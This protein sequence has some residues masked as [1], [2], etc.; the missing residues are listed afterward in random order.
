MEY[1]I[2]QG[3]DIH[4][5]VEGRKLILGGVEIPFEKGLAGHS[6]ADA[7][8]HAV[9]DAALGAAGMGDI[10]E[11]FPPSDMKWKGADSRELL[12][13]AMDKVRAAGWEVVNLDATI[14]AE[15][16]KLSSWKP[17]IRAEVA[18]VLGVAEDRV[19]IKAKTKEK[20][21]SV[22]EGRSIEASAAILLE[23]EGR[24]A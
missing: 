19:N 11:L 12:K 9:T 8:L 7:L 22:G 13:A 24:A 16:P 6:D 17:V 1:R 3:W 14:T 15:R 10:G 2:G 4:R 23:R 5:L 20:Q 21:D 18:R